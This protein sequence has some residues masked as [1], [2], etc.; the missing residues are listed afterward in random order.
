V[1]VQAN[2]PGCGAAIEFKIGSSMVTV[3]AYCRSIVARGDR[4]LED[5][6]K[7]AALVETDSP[8][9]VG[10]RGKYK[11]TPFEIT[12]RAQLAHSAGGVWD[13]WYAAFPKDHWG[14]LA[15]AQGRFYMTFPVPK[16]P[17]ESLPAYDKV[18]LR[19][20][21]LV[22]ADR[23]LRVAE[24]GRAKMVSAEGEIPYR[25]EPGQTFTYADLSGPDH[26][27]GTIGYEED[28][29]EVYLGREVTLDELEIPKKSKA[30]H[31]ARQIGAQQVS[32]PQCGGALALRAPDKT[33]RVACP[34]CG[35]LLDC[36]QGNL[37]FLAALEPGQVKPILP[38]G[39]VGTLPEGPMTVIG[40]IQR[41][42]TFDGVDYH[43]EEYLL[44]EPRLGFRWLVRSD[45]HWSYVR[46]LRP[47]D[48]SGAG[49]TRLYD[50]RTFKLFQKADASVTYVV[51]ECY[52]KVTV[53]ETVQTADYIR[54]PEMLAREMTIAKD[55]EEI[56]WSLGTYLTPEAVET[57]FNIHGLTRPWNIAPNQPYPYTQIYKSWGWLT[58]AAA[59]LAILFIMT[60]SH[61]KVFEQTIV[62]DQN[63]TPER[64]QA[65]VTEQFELAARKNIEVKV[66]AAVDNA[67]LGVEGALV[68][69]AT[70]HRVQPFYLPV[71]F[72]HDVEDG[73]PWSEGGHHNS[74]IL[75]A[76]PAGKYTL[77]L[78]I[79]GEQ[80]KLPHSLRVRVDQGVPRWLYVFVVFGLLSIFPIIML[81][82][83]FNFEYRRWQESDYSPYSSS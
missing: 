26:A 1:S 43:W 62:V 39:S 55:G 66:E 74:T 73:E 67:W 40:M 23:E 52:W 8:L 34:N 59:M 69:D 49:R 77:E 44:Y 33:E 76:L 20:T 15:E 36:H 53:G 11:G 51:G 42:V 82:Y 4:K 14:W 54:P 5:L 63:A 12:G 79:A 60:S 70:P 13:E 30:R 31:D 61:R 64:P 81:F 6:G 32:C 21:V 75:S 28:G 22:A 38:M 47:G 65:Y 80:R 7:V 72:Y 58:L 2:C 46:P 24:K 18:E 27:F 17:V 57:A 71:K 48:V 37:R 19:D 10:L 29:P 9:E 41:S 3:C 68:S 25:L 16:A 56:N 35:S 50:D 83:H 45:N 78:E